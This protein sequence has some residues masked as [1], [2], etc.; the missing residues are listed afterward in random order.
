MKR[1]IKLTE[2][3]LEKIVSKVIKEQQFPKSDINPKK[4]KLGDGGEQSPGKVNDVRELQ[5]KLINLG[6][7]KLKSNKTTGYFGNKTLQAL[8]TY[9]GGGLSKTFNLI[10]KNASNKSINQ[11]QSKT[12]RPSIKSP[13]DINLPLH[14]YAATRF[15]RLEKSTLTEKEVPKETLDVLSD[16]LCE[17]SMRLK[18]CDPNKWSGMDP[19]GERN[20]NYLGYPDYTMLYSKSPSYKKTSFSY[21]GQPSS[22]RGCMLTLGQATIRGNGNGWTITDTYNFDNILETKPQ[23]KTDNFFKASYNFVA[24]GAKALWSWVT[25]SGK[26]VANLEESLSQLHNLGYKGYPVKINVPLNGCKCNS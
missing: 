26:V 9:N 10:N 2:Q 23:L 14:V 11:K 6:L 4:L 5:Q 8:D 22:I 12:N 15:M 20:K 18:T 3:D 16:I 25:G 24:G 7:L 1:V 19:R 13:L 21:D 17:K